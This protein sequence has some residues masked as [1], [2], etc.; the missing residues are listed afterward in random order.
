MSLAHDDDAGDGKT[1]SMRVV[2]EGGPS[3]DACKDLAVVF[4]AILKEMEYQ[5]RL[6]LQKPWNHRNTPSVGEE[7]L[8][9]EEYLARAR[10]AFTDSN[11]TTEARCLS[12]K[13]AAMCARMMLNHGTVTRQEE[14]Q[15]RAGK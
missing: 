8:L 2:V 15:A 3:L 11:D 12:R 4:Q 7:I 10:R 14:Q 6:S 5:L 9:A 1:D 13:I